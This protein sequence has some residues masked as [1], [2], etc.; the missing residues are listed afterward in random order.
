MKNNK[1]FFASLLL[2]VALV[3]AP[4]RFVADRTLAHDDYESDAARPGN[5]R[6]VEGTVSDGL[7][8]KTRQAVYAT[9][10]VLNVTFAG[11]PRFAFAGG[12]A[13]KRLRVSFRLYSLSNDGEIAFAFASAPAGGGAAKR[14]AEVVAVKRG[15]GE[16]LARRLPADVS[17]TVAADGGAELE[18]RS[19][20]DGSDVRTPASVPFVKDLDGAEF[21]AAVR[22]AAGG[23]GAAEMKIDECAMAVVREAD[24]GPLPPFKIDAAPEFDPAEAGWRLAFEDDFEGP[25]DAPFDET[26]WCRPPWYGDKSLARLDGKGNL[27]VLCDFTPGTTNLETTAL[28]TLREQKY[29]YF[30]ARVRFS[31]NNGWWSYFFLYGWSNRNPVECGSEIDIFEDYFTRYPERNALPGGFTLDHNLHVSFGNTIKSLNLNGFVP[32]SFDEFHVIG[33]K[34]TPFEISLYI[35]GKAVKSLTK[36]S[37]YPTVT[38][39]AFRHGAIA[40]PL[41]AIVGGKPFV[42]WGPRD[43]TGFTFPERYLVDWVRIWEMPPADAPK[44]AWKSRPAGG[45]VEEGKTLSF[46]VDVDAAAPLKGVYLF[47]NGA[48][49]QCRTEPP[50]RFE[51]PFSKAAYADTRFM[52]P[53]RQ[54]KEPVWEGLTHSFTVFAQDEEGRVGETDAGVLVVPGTPAVEGEARRVPGEVLGGVRR[55]RHTGEFA[56]VGIDVAKAG[57]YEGVL[58]Y[59]PCADMRGRVAVMVDGVIKAEIKCEASGKP[60]DGPA[61]KAPPVALDLPAGRHTLTLLPCGYVTLSRFDLR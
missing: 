21:G 60:G 61:R 14:T 29:G 15:E 9:D 16:S 44:V 55:G 32:G 59:A 13:A 58:E 8:V 40:V 22:L 37:P 11:K 4:V 31:K 23:G 56:T 54:M 25:E 2:P 42:G 38:F 48:Y 51:V 10:G 30:E 36:D 47:D 50:W 26:K 34:W 41:H 19:L 7:L 3:A 33:C 28:W 39:D 43:L 6:I 5:P 1:L 12:D 52:R 27:A 35:D 53:G 24:E 49:M 17:L 57:R 45:F 20:V 18:V 46:E